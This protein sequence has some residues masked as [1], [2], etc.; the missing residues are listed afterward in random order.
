MNNTR[1]VLCIFG[2]IVAISN[3][4]YADAA[5][6]GNNTGIIIDNNILLR[7]VPSDL[8]QQ[9][10]T[11]ID[12][13]RVKYPVSEQKAYELRQ[14]LIIDFTMK[15]SMEPI[16]QKTV[17]I[18]PGAIP[19]IDGS[20]NATDSLEREKAVWALRCLSGVP[21]NTPI[22]QEIVDTNLL[23][24][25]LLQR[26]LM[27]VSTKVREIALIG[28][29]NMCGLQ[30]NVV[31]QEIFN[32]LQYAISNDPDPLLKSRAKGYYETLIKSYNRQN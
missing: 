23:I 19:I 2:I 12:N 32:A 21:E 15:N 26:S 9:I 10:Q 31:M 30:S 28:L 8:Q 24:V 4:A 6:T 29:N 1:I 7:P 13:C 22:R 20:L 17:E 11:R 27:D 3:P 5:A 16:R 25:F 18:G 14:T